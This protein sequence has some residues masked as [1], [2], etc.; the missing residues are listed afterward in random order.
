MFEDEDVETL[1]KLGLHS[2][3][4]KIYLTLLALGASDVKRV[5][6]SAGIDRGEAYRQIEI[7]LE[8]GLIEK[9]IDIP[10]KFK[11]ML[12]NEAIKVLVQ[13]KNRENAEIAQKVKVLLEKEFN[14]DQLSEED[15]KISIIPGD[16]SRR[17]LPIRY[18]YLQK[19]EVW[20]TQ[21]EVVPFCINLW[22]ETFKKAFARGIKLRAI[23]ELNEPTK[24]ILTVVSSY[25]KENPNFLIRFDNPVL[26]TT[27]AIYDN[28]EMTMYPDR[29]R[30]SIGR[31]VLRTTNP[32]LIEIFKDY[33]ELRWNNAL[34]EIPKNLVE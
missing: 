5:A 29:K 3:Q 10:N 2:A 33:F 27:F 8:K 26:L 28:K 23:A 22:D 17:Q 14:A 11:P 7:L 25:A 9:I 19:E 16:Y 34:K 15:S 4:A 31:Q 30:G 6:Q 20:Y 21:I 18:E 24:E 1:V 32:V 12:L 13:Q